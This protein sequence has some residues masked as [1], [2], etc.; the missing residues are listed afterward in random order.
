ML[1]KQYFTFCTSTL[2]HV[3]NS[4][5][6]PLALAADTTATILTIPPSDYGD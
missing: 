2:C 1:Q 6:Q 3:G 4:I 5:L